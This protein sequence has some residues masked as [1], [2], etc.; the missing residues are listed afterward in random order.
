[1]DK[2]EAIKNSPMVAT[3]PLSIFELGRNKTIK[4]DGKL[5]PITSQAYS[6]FLKRVL[7][8]DPKFVKRFKSVT[9]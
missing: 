3:Y 7:H 2:K 5:I 9:D 6:S 1:M 8:I 4:M